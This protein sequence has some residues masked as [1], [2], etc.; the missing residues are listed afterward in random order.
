MK[1]RFLLLAGALLATALLPAVAAAGK[2]QCSQPSS[3]GTKPV[4][5]DCLYILKAAVGALSCSPACICA[6]S[7]SLPAK[8]RDA[9]LCLRVSVGQAGS[10]ACPCVVGDDFDDSS[11]DPSKWGSGDDIQG[12]G[13]LTETDKVLQYACSPPT[14]YDIAL[15]RWV[16][17]VM[18]YDSDWEARI[19]AG[20]LVAPALAAQYA[21]FGIAVYHVTYADEAFI[22]LY[23]NS[24]GR[25]FHGDLY[26]HGNSAA[27]A[28]TLAI[29]GLSAGSAR[30]TFDATTKI[31]RF[32]YDASG[33]D[34]STWT[35]LGSFG[36]HGSGT[37]NVD[38][39]LTAGETMSIS[40]YG[41][42]Q[43]VSVGPG[44]LFGDNFA[45]SGGVVP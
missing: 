28:D 9:L 41:Y 39:G 16:E 44:Q 8:A 45:V 27:N 37:G 32:Y 36:I 26:R 21:S 12:H 33:D 34:G 29:G 23:A 17:Q 22:E 43:D 1:H 24:A 4:A 2:G 5:S 42:S 38:W 14:G 31:L 6:P 25:G 40:V 15:R 3:N 19:D 20:N 7:G 10:L 13:T 35:E 18:P 30:I 11:E